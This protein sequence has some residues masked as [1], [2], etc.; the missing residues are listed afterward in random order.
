MSMKK[1]FLVVF[2]FLLLFSSINKFFLPKKYS[3]P[4]ATFF[5]IIPLLVQIPF[6]NQLP[7][8][9]VFE[10]NFFHFRIHR[11]MMTTLFVLVFILVMMNINKKGWN[12]IRS[13]FLGIILAVTLS[14]FYYYFV[15]MSLVIFFHITSICK[16]NYL[17]FL[18]DNF[19]NILI[20][21]VTFI[22]FSIPFIINI[23]FLE[24]NFLE[25]MGIILLDGNKKFKL[26]QYCVYSNL[27]LLVIKIQIDT[28]IVTKIIRDF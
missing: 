3:L 16:L 21:F 22:F 10:S 13:F 1:L 26:L 7:L 11:P 28:N 15:I 6:L 8:I 5:L 25:R 18:K 27:D 14:G 2:F 12:S 17:K 24:E 9:N 4:I 23:F 19:K 20:L